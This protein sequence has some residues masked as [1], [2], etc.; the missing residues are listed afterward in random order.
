MLLA[1]RFIA[2][3]EYPKN[4]LSRHGH[5]T[6]TQD[7]ILQPIKRSPVTGQAENTEI[8]KIYLLVAWSSVSK[9]RSV[10]EMNE[11]NSF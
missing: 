6:I 7:P 1:R 8:L 5:L 10:G 9:F 4:I 11:E 3:K 2:G